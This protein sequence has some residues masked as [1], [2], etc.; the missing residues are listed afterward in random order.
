MNG[1]SALAASPAVE[2]AFALGEY[3]IASSLVAGGLAPVRAGETGLAMGRFGWVDR[4]G[5]ARNTRTDI[6]DR[7]GIVVPQLGLL[8]DWRRV[9]YSEIMQAWKVREGLPVT[10]LANGSVW[11]KFANGARVKQPVYAKLLDGSALSGPNAG[12]EL[13]P[14]SV[15]CDCEPGGLAII[16]TWS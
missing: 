15:G 5:I 6:D 10:L 7:L 1:P 2:G 8:T 9:F 14:W 13:T 12:A 4:N 16:T 3:N 11:A